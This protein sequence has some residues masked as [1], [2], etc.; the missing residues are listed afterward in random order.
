MFSATEQSHTRNSEMIPPGG[1]FTVLNTSVFQSLFL[2][3]GIIC[4]YLIIQT[5]KCNGCHGRTGHWENQS[6]SPLLSFLINSQIVII[7][8]IVYINYLIVN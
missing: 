7:Y 1:D 8:Y 6:I 5:I 2:N 3:F 4:D